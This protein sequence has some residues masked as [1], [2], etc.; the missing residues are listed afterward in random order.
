MRRIAGESPWGARSHDEPAANDTSHR[1][2]IP[3]RSVHGAL[4]AL[5]D[6]PGGGSGF[7]RLRKARERI[8]ELRGE[9]EQRGLGLI[10]RAVQRLGVLTDLWECLAADQADSAGELGLF[11]IRAATRLA[12]AEPAGSRRR[13]RRP[14]GPGTVVIVV[15]RIPLP[16]RVARTRRTTPRSSPTS[17]RPDEEFPAIDTRALLSLFTGATGDVAK[18]G[19]EII[20]LPESVKPRGPW[21]P[22]A[23]RSIDGRFTP[24]RAE[25]HRPTG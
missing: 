6:R 19:Q 20:P 14:L 1:A 21:S 4:R 17:R 3:G 5:A 22:P 18:V 7:P 2:G 15:G 16:D 12:R 13:R 23:R 25:G 9:L 11:C 8:V 10:A 24:V